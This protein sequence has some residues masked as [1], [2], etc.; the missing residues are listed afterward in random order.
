MCFLNQSVI[1]IP[2]IRGPGAASIIDCS[3]CIIIPLGGYNYLQIQFEI[4]FIEFPIDSEVHDYYLL[5][6]YQ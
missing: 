4:N 1:I 6:V 2:M 3:P 5:Y